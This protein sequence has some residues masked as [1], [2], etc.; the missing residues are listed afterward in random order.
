MFAT[1]EIVSVRKLEKNVLFF[2]SKET[3]DGEREELEEVECK[4]GWECSRTRTSEQRVSTVNPLG[5][6]RNRGKGTELSMA[7]KLGTQAIFV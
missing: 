4:G 6:C 1:H 2:P 3:T 5:V 7:C